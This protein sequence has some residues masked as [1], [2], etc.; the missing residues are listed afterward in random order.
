[1]NIY[2]SAEGEK[3]VLRF[4][5]ELLNSWPVP[6][7]ELRIKTDLGETFVTAGGAPELPPLLVLHGSMSNSA[8]WL[9]DIASLSASFRVYTVDSIGEPG[10]SSPAR[11]TLSSGAYTPW[12]KA[13]LDGLHIEKTA[14]IG[15]SLGGWMAVD[16]AVNYPERIHA[17]A[18]SV[19]GGVGKQK[20][21]LLHILPYLLLGEWGKKKIMSKIFGDMPENQSEDGKR[22]HEFMNLISKHFRPRTE[23]LPSHTDAELRRLVMPVFAVIGGKDLFLDSLDTKARLEANLPNVEIDFR[24]EGLHFI[25]DRTRV[26]LN[27]LKRQNRLSR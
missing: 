19:P 5:R 2:R 3:A 22:L 16:F 15:E 7:E 23:S 8:F 13:V 26:M 9:P 4:Y 10:F 18:L 12:I 11:P 17:L 20:N 21:F 6:K 24:P 27:F 25:P 1:M 14:M